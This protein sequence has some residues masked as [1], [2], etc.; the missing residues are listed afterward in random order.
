MRTL[1]LF[2]ALAL[3][4]CAGNEAFVFR[5]DERPQYD[6]TLSPAELQSAAQDEG[7]VLLDVRLREDFDASPTLIPGATYRDP[8]SIARWSSA[9]PRDA[10]VVVYCVKGKWVSQ[11]AAH[12]LRQQGYDVYSLSGGIEGWKAAQP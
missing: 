2:A 4:A 11:K 5:N 7:V 1:T 12:Y 8:E 6:R 3:A 9:L 10:K